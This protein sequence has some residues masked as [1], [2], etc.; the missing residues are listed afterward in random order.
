MKNKYDMTPFV[1]RLKNRYIEW[2]WYRKERK[3]KLY[4]KNSEFITYAH[5]NGF[6]H[7][8]YHYARWCYGLGPIIGKPNFNEIFEVLMKGGIFT[9]IKKEDVK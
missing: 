1:Q 9:P 8:P 6:F 2:K 3:I 4:D 5:K 7:S